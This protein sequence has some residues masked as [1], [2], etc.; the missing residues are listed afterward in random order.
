MRINGRAWR[1][2]DDIDGHAVLSAPGLVDTGRGGDL[3]I[4]GPSFG[5]TAGRE[6]APM[7]I[8]DAG[9]SAVVAVSFAPGFYRDAISVGLPLVE[10]A[11]AAAEAQTGDT[12]S[13]DLSAGTVENL[14]TSKTH[15]ITPYPPFMRELTAAGGLDPY[16]RKHEAS[17]APKSR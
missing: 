15:P 3:L 11:E 5:E 7:A 12:L 6:Q 9:I 4:A 1:F 10:S 16:L 8:K 13:I 14:R 2:G 17:A